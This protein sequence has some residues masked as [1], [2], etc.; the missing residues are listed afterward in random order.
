M[1]EPKRNHLNLSR[2]ASLG[3][4]NLDTELLCACNNLYSLS[5]RNGVGD[6]G[7]EGLVVHEEEVDIADV[8]DEEG[9]VAGWHHV[10]GLLVG[11]ETN[12]NRAMSALSLNITTPIVFP[13]NQLLMASKRTDGITIWPLKRLRTRLSIPFGFLHDGS[14][15]MKV[16][17]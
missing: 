11:S 3:I 7:G 13:N 2:N 12:L 8:V 10:A 9:L 17:L 15:R 14:T 4:G 5:R 6:L 1:R 16:S